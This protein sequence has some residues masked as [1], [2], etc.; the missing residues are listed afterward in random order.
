MLREF[1]DG[2][3]MTNL[4]GWKAVPS[5]G[6]R[7]HGCNKYLGPPFWFTTIPSTGKTLFQ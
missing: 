7:L 2:L 4:I 3:D 1:C 6:C 5:T